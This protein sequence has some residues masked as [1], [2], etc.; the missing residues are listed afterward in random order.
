MIEFSKGDIVCNQYAGSNNPYRYLMYLGKSTITQGRYRQ[1]GYT[2]L[3]YDG[4]KIQLFREDDPLYLVGYLPEFH[5]FLS[6]L[7]ELKDFKED[8]YD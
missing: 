8:E 1:K 4:R 3:A 2:C 7:R 6:A 5:S